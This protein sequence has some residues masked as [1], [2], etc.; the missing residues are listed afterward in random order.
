MK[1]RLLVGL[2]LL[3]MVLALP[4]VALGDV[5]VAPGGGTPGTSSNFQL[6]GANPLFARGMNAAIANYGHYIYVGNRTDGSDT[7][8]IGDP[9]R[10][11][12]PCPH[13]HPGILIVDV[14]D[15]AN[16]TVVGEIGPPYA[17]LVGIST[18]ELRVWPQKKLLMV[19]SFRC[20]SVIHACPRG[21]DTTFPFDIRFFDLADP[22]HPRY[23]GSYVTTSAAGQKVKPH[24]MFLWIDP[25][26]SDRALM[27]KS[28]PTSLV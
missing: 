8:G 16:P 27:W 25:R 18:R 15:P 20:S 3:S 22:L 5:T 6:V 13:P 23:I 4:L 14:A 10:G 17:G 28:A 11:V 1:R 12:T 9:R 21:T 7:C 2:T 19:M 26:N 24:E